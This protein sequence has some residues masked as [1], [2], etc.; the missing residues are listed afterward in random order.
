MLERQ[1]RGRET[2]AQAFLA[3][4]TGRAMTSSQPIERVDIERVD[5]ERVDRYPN[6]SQCYSTSLCM[7]G[8]HN[9]VINLHGRIRSCADWH[10]GVSLSVCR[11]DRIR[12][13]HTV[14]VIRYD[15]MSVLMR[16]SSE[17]VKN[18]V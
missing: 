9:N 13:L 10:K 15:F 2:K 18:I 11:S 4:R 3:I 1:D 16:N 17:I 6:E 14:P 12:V 5:I 7:H 8:A